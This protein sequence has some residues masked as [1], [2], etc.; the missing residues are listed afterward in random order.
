[1]NTMERWAGKV[2]LVTGA[3]SGIGWEIAKSLVQHDIQ[4][5]GLARRFDKL[6]ELAEKLGKS[7]FYPIQCDVTKENDILRAF[8]WAE[9]RL[10]GVDILVNNAGNTMPT[11]IIDSSIEQCREVINSNLIAPMIFAREFINA[12]RKR[13]VSGHI[14]NI[15]SITGR[16]PETFRVPIGI[17]SVTKSSLYTLGVELRNEIMACN[18]DIRVTTINPGGVLTD[19]LKFALNCGDEITEKITLLSGKDIADT[20][21]CALGASPGAEVFELTIIPQKIIVGA[22]VPQL[23]N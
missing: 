14:I 8:K 18:L 19:L 11:L 23:E 4:V 3:S 22:P 15:S 20:V 2:A 13:N 12:I 6:Q 7:K 10:G 1:M 16:Y 17:Y 5:V 21:I 9:E